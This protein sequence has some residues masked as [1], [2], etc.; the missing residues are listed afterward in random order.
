MRD[1]LSLLITGAVDGN[2]SAVETF[3][4]FAR[5]HDFALDDLWIAEH[6]GRPCAATLII[7][8]AGRTGMLFLSPLADRDA[9]TAASGLLRT[10]R[11]A[12]DPDRI[13]LIQA[14]FDPHQRP[15]I[16]VMQD[17]G[18]TSLA[19]L[20]YLQRG[21][22]TG[23]RP[24]ELD[25]ACQC[26]TWSEAARDLFADAILASYEDTLD[27]PGLLG[28]RRIDDILAGH[29]ATGV[30]HPDLWI[31]L[32]RDREPVAVMLINGVPGQPVM[33]LVYLGVS[34]AWRRRA[35]AHNLMEH[36]LSAASRHGAQR[37]ILAVDRANKPARRL[38]RNLRFTSTA[39]K[40]AMI[41]IVGSAPAPTA[42]ADASF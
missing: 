16:A 3:V 20:M 37:M 13:R 35:L 23:D 4:K 27:C 40:Q 28:V 11:A 36:G 1:G 8:N 9:R 7:P 12:Q 25:G 15:E 17:A 34:R 5:D 38:Y 39:C 18:F 10:V 14:L 30:F 29:M 32:H 24:L 33:E 2:P 19:E 26:T 22:I 31:V 42:R 21:L 41:H 6:R